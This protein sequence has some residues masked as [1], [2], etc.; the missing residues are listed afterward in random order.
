[1]EPFPG[2]FVTNAML[3][4]ESQV[5]LSAGV[6]MAINLGSAEIAVREEEA[7]KAAGRQNQSARRASDAPARLYIVHNA[8]AAQP[9]TMQRA[10]SSPYSASS[11][12]M[13]ER[14]LQAQIG[15]M[16]RDVFSDVA[17]EP[18]PQRFITLLEALEIKEK[19]P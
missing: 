12:G 16:L 10:P 19:Q 15:R 18:V 14:T 7:E 3:S 9:A 4:G 6:K 13:F 1:M 11:R 8:D 17:E 5:P 2:T